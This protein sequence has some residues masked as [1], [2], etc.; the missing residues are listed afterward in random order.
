[1]AFPTLA[2]FQQRLLNQMADVYRSSL[3]LFPGTQ[4][5]GYLIGYEFLL[6]FLKND[7]D[8]HGLFPFYL[9]GNKLYT[10]PKYFPLS[11]NCYCIISSSY[12]TSNAYKKFDPA[13]G[14]S[15]SRL[16]TLLLGHIGGISLL[17]L[18]Y[19]FAPMRSKSSTCD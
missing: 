8:I 7:A 9:G 3:L 14:F 2:L 17:W 19:I 5:A 10:I 15:H 16:R 11:F 13:G 6:L 12:N 18:S 1:M 4:V